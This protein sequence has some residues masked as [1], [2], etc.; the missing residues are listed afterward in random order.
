MYPMIPKGEIILRVIPTA[1]HSLEDVQI[2][3]EAFKAVSAK[4]KNGEYKAEVHN[5]VM[6]KEGV[7]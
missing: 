5:P 4:L 2:T 1:A 3:L 6:E 7:V